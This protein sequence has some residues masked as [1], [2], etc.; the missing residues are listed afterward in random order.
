MTDIFIP[1]KRSWIMSQIRGKNTK[2]EI[3][4]EG[5]LKKTGL[6]FDKNEKEK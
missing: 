6:K 5:V 2:I 3:Q 4:M 1:K